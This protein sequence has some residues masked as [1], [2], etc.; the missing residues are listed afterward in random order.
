MSPEVATTLRARIVRSLASMVAIGLG[1]HFV[2]PQLAGL[3]ATGEAIARAT[4]WLP[5]VVVVLEAASLFAYGGLLVVLLRRSGLAVHGSFVQRATLVGNAVGRA[6]P[7]GSGTALAIMVSSFRGRGYDPVRTGSAVWG[8]GLLS[9]AILGLLLPVG[10]AIGLV[11]GHAGR[12]GLSAAVAAIGVVVAARLVPVA[13]RDP[14]AFA[15][16]VRRLLDRVVPSWLRGRVD[17]AAIAD[18]VGRG[19]ANVGE[20][21]TDPTVLR[22]AAVLAATNWVLDIAVV[23]VLAMTVGAG[24]PLTAILLAYV[25]AQLAAAVPLTPGGVGIVETA[26]IGALVASGAPASAATT[27][28]LGW[29]LISHWLPIPIG[30]A[31]L[32]TITTST[33]R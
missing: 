18:G 16:H 33:P 10:A 12:I 15:A 19:A 11:G 13:L 2:L 31:L 5:V 9:S 29:R 8:A 20:L 23:V 27:T 25:V 22:R 1:V 32:P 21:A 24:T 30:L 14:D 28:V 17:P 6:L 3:R 4:W 7:G 26:M